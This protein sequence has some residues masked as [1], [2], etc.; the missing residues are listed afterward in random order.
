M[1]YVRLKLNQPQYR[2]DPW[3][4]FSDLRKRGDVI[5]IKMPFMGKAWAATTYET[6]NE[7]LK[8]DQLFVRDPV[9]A[10]RKTYFPMQWIL[11]R[12]FFALAQN[13]MGADWQKHRRL[14]LLVDRAFAMR[15]IDQMDEQIL[16]LANEQLDILGGKL[17]SNGRADLIADFARPFPLTVICELLGLPLEDR[18]KFS[19][20]FAPLSTVSS[21]L[22]VFRISSGIKAIIKYLKQEFDEVRQNPRPGLITQLVQAELEGDRLN[23]EELLSMVFVL[24]VAGHETT[25]HLISNLVLTMLQHPQTKDEILANQELIAPAIDETLRYCSPIQVGKPRYLAR[26]TEFGGQQ[27]IT[28]QMITPL[29]AC[30]NYD[31]A[32]FENPEQF[33]IHRERNYHM[34][35]GSGPHVCLGMKLAKS[36][37]TNAVNSLF[38]RYPQLS[39]DFDTSN[40]NWGKRI[41]MRN[42]ADFWVTVGQ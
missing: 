11:P 29:L 10:G 30:A 1:R 19:K 33:N 17:R 41:G 23:E 31:P 25:T 8:N 38:Q 5:R 36:E 4:S 12:A 20:W 3:T 42:L 37:T 32:R 9:N 28:G 6:V 39:A 24:L 27:L 35:F 34:T 18:P 2:Q 16:R 13:M 21:I 40:P 14:R 22:G 7:V 26:D 15:N